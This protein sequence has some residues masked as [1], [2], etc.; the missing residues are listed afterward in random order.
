MG[1]PVEGVI[2]FQARHESAALGEL[3]RSGVEAWRGWRA[4]LFD[5][6]LLGQDPARYGGLAYGNL[7]QRLPPWSGQEGRRP[8]VISGAQTSG[9]ARVG[10]DAFCVVRRFNLDGN[11]VESRGPMLPSSESMTHGALYDLSN[12][13]RAVVHGHH[14]LIFKWADA[15]RLPCTAPDVAYGTPEMARSVRRLRNQGDLMEKRIFVMKGHEDGVVAFGH[16]ADEAASRLLM[17]LAQAS[18]LEEKTGQ[19]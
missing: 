19:A 10:L 1:E 13:I 12:R 16:N 11:W 15:L 8:F 14:P 9:L 4:L 3:A 2:K 18:S 6:G 17:V 7:S 5:L